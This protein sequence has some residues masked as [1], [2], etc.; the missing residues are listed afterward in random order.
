MIEKCQS[1]KTSDGKFHDTIE[2]AQ[3]HELKKFIDGQFLSKDADMNANGILDVL[4][5]QKETI[6]DI[7]TMNPS[8]K[9]KARRI[10]G[11][12]KKRAP[13]RELVAVKQEIYPD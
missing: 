2:A 1:F 9:P 7:L 6:V 4:I 11:G 5:N 3:R 12:T 13:K 10:N 8:S